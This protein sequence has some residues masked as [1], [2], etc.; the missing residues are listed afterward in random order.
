MN[1]VGHIVV[2]G[3]GVVGAAT[4]YYLSAAGARVTIVERE[5][6]GNQASAWSAGGLNPLQ[7][8]EGP[9]LAFAMESFR[10]H[11]ELWPELERITGKPLGARRISMAYVAADEAATAE[12][13][14]LRD[15]FEGASADGFSARWLDPEALF[16]HEPRLA[17][18]LVGGIMTFG[19]AILDSQTLTVLLAEAAQTLGATVVEGEV[20]GIA[21]T[22]GRVTGVDVDG[23]PVACDAAVV[24]MGPWSGMAERWLGVPLPIEPLKGEILRMQPAGPGLTADVVAPGISLFAREDGQVWFASTKQHAGFD[25][26][27]SQW[28]YHTLHD[29]ALG[30]M[31][32]L[33][34][35]DLIRHTACLRP[36]TPDDLPLLGAVPRRTGA[37]IGSGGGPKGILLAPGMGK[38]LADL[39]LTGRTDL[40]IGGCA[41]ERFVTVAP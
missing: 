34:E 17:K 40:S 2:I 29:A 5:G 3:G 35:A 26:E 39:I 41:P 33:V 23:E 32:S 11:L 8:I 14:E 21:L 31:P 15:A 12:L 27:P 7:G 13:R 19:N 18:H 10:L 37:Y 4:A 9:I 22:D 6:I 24:T 1:E 38:A 30:L 36:V 16:T 25:R 28:G 20:T